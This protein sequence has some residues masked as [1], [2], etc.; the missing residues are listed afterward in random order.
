MRDRAEVDNNRG[1]SN[2]RDIGH[3]EPLNIDQEKSAQ[4]P[5]IAQLHNTQNVN[6]HV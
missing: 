1:H 3:R 5:P 4:K 6:N 2:I